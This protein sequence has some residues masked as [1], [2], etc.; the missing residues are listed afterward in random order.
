MKQLKKI[1]SLVVIITILLNLSMSAFAI[2]NN[3]NEIDHLFGELTETIALSLLPSTQRTAI[4]YESKIEDIE[5]QLSILG[6]RKLSKDELN[7][8]FREKILIKNC[9]LD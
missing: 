5:E 4:E 8:F 7:N 3:E 9:Q 6:V 1:L 2:E